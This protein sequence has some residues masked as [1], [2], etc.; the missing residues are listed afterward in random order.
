MKGVILAA[1]CGTRLSPYSQH[2]SKMLLPVAGRPLIDHTLEAFAQVGVTDVAVVT[3]YRGDLLMEQVGD[4]SRQGLHIEYVPNPDY[5][6]G[7]ALSVY[8]A[9]AFTQGEPFLLSMG[10]HM[11][12]PNLLA[13]L[14][15]TDEAANA[16]AVD[17]THSARNMEE[18][19]RVLVN[20]QELVIRIGKR[21]IEWNG[22]DAGAFRLTS[23]IFDAIAGLID[24]GE[25]QYEL[26]RA[27]T[28][29]MG[30]GD[31]LQARDIS[32]CFWHDVD[33]WEDLTLVRQ[34][35]GR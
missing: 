1:G 9:R 29:M 14:L 25:G 12:S 7:N 20:S 30:H 21:L 6:E 5:E 28:R 2:S 10:D 8:V 24:D 15:E 17:F 13:R 3:G 26:S 35:M 32:G 16:L 11:V 34:T 22:T 23:S 31:F 19:T 4:G 33:T 18:G 27:I